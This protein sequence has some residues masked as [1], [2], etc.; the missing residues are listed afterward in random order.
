MLDS[1]GSVLGRTE[2]QKRYT[3]FEI[4]DN[5]ELKSH[6]QLRVDMADHCAAQISEYVQQ[7]IPVAAASHVSGAP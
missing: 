1:S 4:T 3:G 2:G 6:R 5:P 7:T